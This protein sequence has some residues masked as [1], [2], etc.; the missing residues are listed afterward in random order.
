MK[1]DRCDGKG[2]VEYEIR[3]DGGLKPVM[4]QCG[5]CRDV[6]KYSAEVKRRMGIQTDA[7]VIPFRRKNDQIRS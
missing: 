3:R 6:E 2:Y 1:C 7:E 5:K 4:E